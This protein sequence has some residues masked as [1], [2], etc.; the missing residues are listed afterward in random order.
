MSA[1]TVLSMSSAVLCGRSKTARSTAR[2]CAVTCRPCW[3][4]SASS[5]AG[6]SGSWG[7]TGTLDRILESV[8]IWLNASSHQGQAPFEE[9]EEAWEEVSRHRRQGDAPVRRLGIDE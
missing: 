7:T 3:R 1:R 2:R 4:T 9:G 5:S 8:Q 6:D